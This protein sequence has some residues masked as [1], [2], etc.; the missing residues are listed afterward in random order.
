VELGNIAQFDASSARSRGGVT[1]MMASS[2]QG[3]VKSLNASIGSV[4]VNS[5]YSSVA[6][7]TGAADVDSWLTNAQNN[8]IGR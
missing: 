6:G 5:A 4:S 2:A 7:T 8:G 3:Y 1:R